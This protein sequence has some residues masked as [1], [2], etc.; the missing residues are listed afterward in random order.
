M[1]KYSIKELKLKLITIKKNNKHSIK[2]K[3]IGITNNSI[4][5]NAFTILYIRFLSTLEDEN[6][7]DFSSKYDQ[8]KHLSIYR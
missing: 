8:G 1:N 6:L 2:I 4:K 5:I 3:M 7:T